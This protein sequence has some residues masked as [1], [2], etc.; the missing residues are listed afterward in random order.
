VTFMI[1]D[2]KIKPVYWAPPNSC[3]E[4]TSRSIVLEMPLRWCR[5]RDS[6]PRLLVEGACPLQTPDYESGAL[7]RL[8]YPGFFGLAPL[9]HFSGYVSL[10]ALK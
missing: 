5:G 7:A 8:G 6:S 3:K 9:F 4:A 1:C 2:F 10:F